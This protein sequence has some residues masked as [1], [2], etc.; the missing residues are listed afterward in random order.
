MVLTEPYTYCILE[1]S[2]RNHARWSSAKDKRLSGCAA[3]MLIETSRC[4]MLQSF[5]STSICCTQLESKEGA[6]QNETVPPVLNG[7]DD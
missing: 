6:L 7:T 2:P 5:A 3:K 1:S 4:D